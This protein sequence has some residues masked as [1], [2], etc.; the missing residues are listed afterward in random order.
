MPNLQRPDAY[1]GPERRRHRVFLTLN[2]EYHCRDDICIAV[3]NLKT[4][5]FNPNHPALGRRMTGGIRFNEEG[6][7]ASFSRP[8]EQPH[9]GETLFFS[10]E[11]VELSLQTSALK[12][13]ER[14]P[15]TVVERYP[16]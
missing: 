2:S 13:I 3:R 4:G 12:A 14:P 15:K 7:V 9:I 11:A 6:S 5:R 1:R 16:H 10:D 8:G